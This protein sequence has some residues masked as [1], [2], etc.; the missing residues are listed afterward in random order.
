M[1]RLPILLLMLT[2]LCSQA[3]NVYVRAGASGTGGDWSNARAD[4]PTALL[5][6]NTYYVATGTYTAAHY[7]PNNFTTDNINSTTPVLI[8]KA[9]A[10]DHGTDTGWSSSY[11][12]G[13]AVWGSQMDFY[14]CG[15]YITFNGFSG[16]SA[17]PWGFRFNFSHGD[18]GITVRSDGSVATSYL[19]FSYIE[20]VGPDDGVV[21]ATVTE[22]QQ[23]Y[24]IRVFEGINN[25][26]YL[27]V[28]YCYFHG[29]S[30]PF[31]FSSC[32]NL[33]FEHNVAAWA[34]CVGGAHADCLYLTASS[35]CVIRYNQFYE[36][37]P[38]CID[39][40]GTCNNWKVYGNIVYNIQNTSSASKFDDLE[41]GGTYANHVYYNNT[42]VGIPNVFYV[43]NTSGFT[44]RNN[45][46]YNSGFGNATGTIDHNLQ[47]A[48][49]PFVSLSTKDFHITSATGSGTPRDAGIA[50]ASEYATDFDGNTRG[51]DGGWDIGAYEYATGAPATDPASITT[52][53]VGATNSTTGGFSLSVTA[54][55]AGTLT[56][57]WRT[58][59]VILTGATS[60]SYGAIPATTKQSGAYSVVVTNAFGSITS[61]T[62]QVLITNAV[63][64]TNT[65]GLW[66]VDNAATGLNNGTS[67]ANAWKS[68]SSIV[69]SGIKAG[70]T[71]YISGGATGKVYNATLDCSSVS[72][73]IKIAAGQDAGHTGRVII[74]GAG[75]QHGIIVGS[76]KWISGNVG[77][78]NNIVIRNFLNS[79]DNYNY[80]AID[81]YSAV[82]NVID[83]VE[84]YSCCSGIY[85]AYPT[86]VVIS[87]CY[88]HDIRG[89]HAIC[90]NGSSG[91]YDANLI[92]DCTVQVNG[93][94]D[95]GGV[96]PD[97]VQGSDGGSVYN[98]TFYAASG[99]Q[100]NVPSPQ[101]MDGVQFLGMYW[102]V[103]NNIITDMH[104][105]AVEIGGYD[106]ATG[107]FY[108]YNNV[109]QVATASVNG[110]Q[111]GIEW[112][113]N[114]NST[115]FT[116]VRVC[117]NTFVDIYGYYPCA[118]AA[119]PGWNGATPSVSSFTIENNIF[120][121]CYSPVVLFGA[122]SGASVGN[123][124]ID[125]NAVYAGAHGG[126]AFSVCGST[127][128][129]S[130]L[131]TGNVAFTTYSERSG[132]NDIH[133]KSTDTIAKDYGVSLASFFTT[134]KDGVTRPQGSAW[135]IGAYE[136]N[137]GSTSVAPS[138][139]TQPQSLTVNQ[140]SNATF[141][142]TAAG[143]APLT[144]QWAFGSTN[145]SGAT[146]SS[147]TRSNVQSNQAGNYLVVVRN[148]T[149]TATSSVAVLTVNVPPAPPQGLI[150]LGVAGQ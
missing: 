50:L 26:P 139:T 34:S 49:S 6:G 19:T 98:C 91:T 107:H 111:R 142:V 133:L 23:I 146:A 122:E 148:S 137:S 131:R 110:Y 28:S 109:F 61:A 93:T 39:S 66:Y 129:Q 33:L 1:N 143:T 29:M 71:V 134:D 100:V 84:I 22:A 99:P 63:S 37:A 72:T 68:F 4:L 138:I 141:T 15:G 47:A 87:N 41:G 119:A 145:I 95:G 114:G 69:W 74:D 108:I 103:Y 53:P 25:S 59:G 96:G 14:W 16:N 150:V 81:G 147:Y 46:T 115:S 58:N 43:L 38:E 117:N 121:N 101:H 89:D 144:Y 124:T 27:T 20:G 40:R 36:Y 97:C 42:F 92:H 12:T 67:W 112:S 135:D 51:A 105:A 8:K 140:G 113:E 18:S 80:D 2:C 83:H 21:E 82:G 60:A 48:S 10:S 85:L 7:Y 13:Q 90:I 30:N 136:Y 57:Q 75:L 102:K 106:G 45:L 64:S 11:G 86:P 149:G 76:Q 79:S 125:Y 35:G 31:Y 3:A 118:F 130:H 62:V 5:R 17:S 9:T 127:P 56:Y 128:T 70:E 116:D 94:M 24:G 88:I 126:T 78:S 44:I 132:G 32:D 65:G 54:S 52:Q 120:Y 73:R 55:G 104:N 123:F 77:G